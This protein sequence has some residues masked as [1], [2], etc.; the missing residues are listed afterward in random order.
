MF[1]LEFSAVT[2]VTR[3]LLQKASKAAFSWPFYFYSTY[4]RFDSILKVQQQK[5]SFP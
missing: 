5:G 4:K 2:V 3:V 1:I